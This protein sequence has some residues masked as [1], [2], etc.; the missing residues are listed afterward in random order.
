MGGLRAVRVFVGVESGVLFPEFSGKIVK[1]L[2][3][4]VVGQL[5]LFRGLRGVLAPV[6]V[7]PLFRPGRGR[8]ELGELVT[9]RVERDGSGGWRLV[10]VEVGG[11]YVFH[12]GG[13]GGFVSLVGDAL[14]R[15]RGRELV[16]KIGEALVSYRVELVE[17]VTSSIVEK[18]FSGDRVTLYLKGPCKLFNIFTPSRL[19]KF[20]VSAPEVLMT[21]YMMLTGQHTMTSKVLLEAG[22]LLGK[23]VETYYSLTTVRYVQVPLGQGRDPGMIGKITYIVDTR[24]PEERAMLEKVL[25]AAEI[26]GIGE[27]RANGFGTVVWAPK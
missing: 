6:H 10:P 19:P 7:S 4:A 8:L 16:V 1:T 18:G 22:R 9:A 20:N 3:Y 27:S 12:V 24:S 2:V 21:P 25:A 5:R 13:D 26:A 17:D 11:E 14:E 23:L 15:F